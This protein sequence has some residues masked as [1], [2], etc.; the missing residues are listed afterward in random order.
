M[1]SKFAPTKGL[2]LITEV[3]V[4]NTPNVGFSQD[5]NKKEKYVFLDSAIAI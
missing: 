3:R 5:Y 2:R 1:L 4:M